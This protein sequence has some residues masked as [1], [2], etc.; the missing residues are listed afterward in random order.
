[1]HLHAWSQDPPLNR[2]KRTRSPSW[3]P[4][5]GHLKIVKAM[6]AKQSEGVIAKRD[7]TTIG[8][9]IMLGPRMGK[10]DREHLIHTRKVW[11]LINKS[12]LRLVSSL[13]ELAVSGGAATLGWVHHWLELNGGRFY[14]RHAVLGF[15]L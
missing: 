2:K 4:S 15:S 13:K 10:G 3:G 9:G 6:Q 1:M 5:V 12:V 7:R 11:D 14:S 8:Y